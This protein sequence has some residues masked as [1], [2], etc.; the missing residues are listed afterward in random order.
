[1]SQQEYSDAERALYELRNSENGDARNCSLL[2][3]IQWFCE[4]YTDE[5]KVK[6]IGEYFEAFLAIKYAQG[7]R[8]DTIQEIEKILG[9][10]AK[11]FAHANVTLMRYPQLKSWVEGNSNGPRSYERVH[12]MVKHFFGYLSGL[13]KNTPNPSPILRKSP[14]EGHDI[15]F[16]DDEADECTNITIFTAAECKCLLREAQRHNAQRMFLW[17]LFTGM[18][19]KESIRFWS[20]PQWGWKLISEDLSYIS[21]PKAVSKTRQNRVIEVNPTLKQW[22]ECYRDHPS[23]MTPNWRYKYTWVRQNVLPKGKLDADVAR[24]TLISMMIKDG[25]GWAE[26]EMQM[27]NK[28][29]VQMR[30]Y[31]SLI[32]ARGEVGAFYGLTPDK[33]EHEILETEKRRQIVA[34][35][36]KQMLVN[37]IKNQ[38]SRGQAA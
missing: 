28:K 1:M 9:K 19:P 37:R 10:F 27:G 26:I 35:L 33:F 25:K 4:H 15:F 24:H 32:T 23:F 29:D 16:Q 7:R 13:S 22:L 20:N 38:P 31:A 21:V 11:D 12:H 14:F 6:P 2:K 18:R 34:K 5:A 36:K 30:H 17:L 3:A 8:P